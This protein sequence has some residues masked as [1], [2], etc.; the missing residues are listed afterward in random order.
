M[1]KQLAKQSERQ[2]FSILEAQLKRQDEQGRTIHTMFDGM[3]TMY[4][5]FTEGME[6]IKMLVQ[7]VR[8]S[9]T[10]TDTECY[11][12]QSAVA[13][14]SISLTKDRINEEEE[15]YFPKVVGKYR[16]MIWKHLKR[17]FHVPKYNHI[18]RID[19]EEARTFVLNFRPE[20]YI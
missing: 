7:E 8:D 9:K 12:L 13:L 18:R 11:E 4:G 2:M 10:I 5:E 20:D 15:E 6:E 14:K 19:F 17:K 1:A 3:K 16:W